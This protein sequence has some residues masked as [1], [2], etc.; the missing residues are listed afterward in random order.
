LNISEKKAR[1]AALIKE[2]FLANMSHEIRTPLNAII[3][4]TNLLQR[5]NLDLQAMQHVQTIQHSGENLLTIINDVLD[6]S[7]IEAGMMRIE[8]APFSIRAL[9]QSVVTMFRSK[10][11]EKK[12]QLNA[13]VSDDIP[14]T[15]EGDAIR[16]TQILVNLVGNAIK[17]TVEGSVDIDISAE[18]R[19]GN[20]I[21]TSIVVRDTGIG[22]KKEKLHSIF[23]RFQQA[24]ASVTRTYGGTGLGLAIVDE[25]VRL[26]QGTVQ[27]ESEEGK[28]T[29]FTIIIPYKVS[30]ANIRL[31]Q[32]KTAMPHKE[33]P[34]SGIRILVAEDN[35][36]N[37]SLLSQ[38][39]KSWNVE[40]D[41]AANG[42]IALEMLSKQAYN[43]VLMDIQMPVMDG[44]SATRSI[45]EDL[46]SGIPVV[47]MTA[48]AMAGEREKCLA[49]GMNEYLSKPIRQEQLYAI[50]EKFANSKPYRL[51][52]L[53]YMQEISM[54][55]NEYEKSVTGQFLETIPGDLV[56]LQTTWR[57]NNIRAM[58]QVAHNMKTSISVMGLNTTLDPILD[59]LEYNELDESAFN[60]LF[61][62]LQLTCDAALKEARH[63]YA[64]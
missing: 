27:A 57:N 40:F 53:R 28:G 61:S 52:D 16:L 3:G 12:L 17:F 55:N 50:I 23:E 2:N 39:L 63:F 64:S 29:C 19:S 9:L 60:H 46:P 54:G 48:H 5:R 41:M 22:I 20:M 58:R 47:A 13:G 33:K 37:Q 34:F 35:E 32:S 43:M 4:F 62:Q 38:I 26:Q 21:R 24:E 10:A 11:V 42:K 49:L 56:E 36:I 44:Y 14:D 6:L 45:R 7:K 59:Q 15:L 1:D 25:L 18:R 8:S 51:I 30:S 31:E